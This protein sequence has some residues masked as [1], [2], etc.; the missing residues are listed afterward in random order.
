MPLTHHWPNHGSSFFALLSMSLWNGKRD[1]LQFLKFYDIENP[2]RFEDFGFPTVLASITAVLLH[3]L[4]SLPARSCIWSIPNTKTVMRILSNALRRLQKTKIY[5]IL[6]TG[7]CDITGTVV[8]Q[9]QMELQ[10]V[11][12]LQAQDANAFQKCNIHF[13]YFQWHQGG[14]KSPP[15][16]IIEEWGIEILRVQPALLVQ[17]AGAR[18]CTSKL[19]CLVHLQYKD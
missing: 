3:V 8:A 16:V 14:F 17:I 15:N 9:C 4:E 13:G 18:A 2:V 7:Y 19:M 11:H 1:P 6:T 12:L 10:H 5:Y